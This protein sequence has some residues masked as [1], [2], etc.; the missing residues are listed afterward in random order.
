MDVVGAL[1]YD[2]EFKVQQKHREFLQSQVWG[3]GEGLG[4]EQ[5]S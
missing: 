2:P 3:G 4:F 1:E 5:N